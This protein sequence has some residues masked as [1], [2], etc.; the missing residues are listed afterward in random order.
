MWNAV[1]RV[2]KPNGNTLKVGRN[3]LNKYFNE[4]AASLINQKTMTEQYP[5]SQYY[6]RFTKELLNSKFTTLMKRN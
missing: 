1:H 5:F 4:T 2:I 3:N 6:Q